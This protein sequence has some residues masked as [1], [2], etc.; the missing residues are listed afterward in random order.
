ML[1]WILATDC[2]ITYGK[3]HPDFPDSLT[4]TTNIIGTPT[5]MGVY[6][7]K[8]YIA[9]KSGTNSYLYSTP[10]I[11]TSVYS[12]WG[13]VDDVFY[14]RDIDIIKAFIGHRYG[15]YLPNSNCYLRYYAA[16]DNETDKF[17][18]IVGTPPT[19]APTV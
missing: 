3:H 2:I 16:L 14:G 12:M 7:D 17:S 4:K 9:T 1:T 6:G 10:Y 13:Y 11:S 15:Y 19:I 5:A 8:L 18:F